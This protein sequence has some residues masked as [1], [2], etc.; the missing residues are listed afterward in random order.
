MMSQSERRNPRQIPLI[1]VWRP[2]NWTSAIW[3]LMK[4]N[5]SCGKRTII[6]VICSNVLV[7]SAAM[8]LVLNYRHVIA[9]WDNIFCSDWIISP[10][11]ETMPDG[12]AVFNRAGTKTQRLLDKSYECEGLNVPFDLVF[13]WTEAL[14]TFR[15]LLQ[16]WAETT[17]LDNDVQ[18]WASSLMRD[19][20]EKIQP[21]YYNEWLFNVL[22]SFLNEGL[23]QLSA[24]CVFLWSNKGRKPLNFDAEQWYV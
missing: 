3:I 1:Y 2:G 21:L 9:K 23:H 6:G 12:R 17:H 10:H 4:G 19:L 8:K 15:S 20:T 13:L 14:F 22:R 24:D 5:E 18:C 7:T 16:L 11:C